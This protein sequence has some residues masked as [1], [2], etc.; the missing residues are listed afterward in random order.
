MCNSQFQEYSEP[1]HFRT[2]TA[3][4]NNFIPASRKPTAYVSQTKSLLP[5]TCSRDPD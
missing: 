4:Q 1:R 3:V 2:H 5:T